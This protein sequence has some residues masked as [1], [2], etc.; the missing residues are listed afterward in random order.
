[1]FGI[2]KKIKTLMNIL[3]YQTDEKIHW[4]FNTQFFMLLVSIFMWDISKYEFLGA[5]VV[6]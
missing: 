2:T 6:N 5:N 1:M 3:R 4:F